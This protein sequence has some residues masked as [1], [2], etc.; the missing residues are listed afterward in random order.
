MK[1]IS[2]AVS[3]LKPEFDIAGMGKKAIIFDATSPVISHPMGLVT[4]CT[5]SYSVCEGRQQHNDDDAN[6]LS[7]QGWV[8]LNASLRCLAGKT[9]A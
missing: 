9:S 5:L 7:L 2:F 3:Y 6:P 8:M 1:V 4:W